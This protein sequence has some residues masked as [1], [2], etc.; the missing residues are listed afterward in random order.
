MEALRN[1]ARNRLDVQPLKRKVSKEKVWHYRMLPFRILYRRVGFFRKHPFFRHPLPH[2]SFLLTPY[3]SPLTDLFPSG[4]LS[5][6]PP[7]SPFFKGG[8]S[9]GSPPLALG[10][11]KMDA[12]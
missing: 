6:N 4:P 3:A 7:P 10:L 8:T 5:K 11:Q 1:P 9:I 12:R 2:D